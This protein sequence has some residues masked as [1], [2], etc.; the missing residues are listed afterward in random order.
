MQVQTLSL[1]KYFKVCLT[2]SIL[3]FQVSQ[4]RIEFLYFEKCFYIFSKLG[5]LGQ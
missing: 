5:Y 2:F 4:L 3:D 1:Q